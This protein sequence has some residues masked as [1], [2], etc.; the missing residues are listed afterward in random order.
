MGLIAAWLGSVLF[1]TGQIGRGQG[2][3]QV[4]VGIVVIV[5]GLE[6]LGW[7][8][9]QLARLF[10]SSRWLSQVLGRA[11]HTGVIRGAAL[12][13]IVN[14]LM[15]CSMTLAM[16][17]KATTATTP[18]QGALLLLMFGL[19]TL[20]AMLLASW[21]F[22]RIGPLARGLLQ[23]TAG[24]LMISLGVLTL[25]EGIRVFLILSQLLG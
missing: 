22:A 14:A 23:K 10:P 5:L 13:G 24:A 8:P 3:L 19:G 6:M 25:H 18:A 16:A 2:A 15:P 1:A 7:V 4:L 9:L 21:L 17:A 11:R 20:P 12:A